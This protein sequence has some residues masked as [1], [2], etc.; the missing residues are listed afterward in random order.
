MFLNFMGLNRKSE[1][2]MVLDDSFI[3]FIAWSFGIV[4]ALSGIFLITQNQILGGLLFAS[5]GVL[6]ALLVKLNKVTLDKSANK[7]IAS[8][9][10]LFGSKKFDC[11]LSQIS[12]VSFIQTYSGRN[13]T[14]STVG[15]VLADGTVMSYPNMVGNVLEAQQVATF[16]GV[17][18]D[19]K[20][21]M[22]M[23]QVADLIKQNVSYYQQTGA[24]QK[25]MQDKFK[26]A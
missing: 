4:F 26:E 21:P 9:F 20:G 10:S 18:L 16:L 8:V 24:D 5:I 6:V 25:K 3:F 12:K 2:L 23:A 17:P 22:G 7:M 14:Q 19:S 13:S 15:L 11:E 1:T